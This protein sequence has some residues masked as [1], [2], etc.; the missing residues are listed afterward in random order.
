MGMARVRIKEKF[1][2]AI[3]HKICETNC[4]FHVKE[5]TRG[6]FEFLFFKIYLLVLTKI[7]FLARRLGTRVSFDEVYTIS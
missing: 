2:E 6:K 7:S 1:P 5:R 4:S 3:T